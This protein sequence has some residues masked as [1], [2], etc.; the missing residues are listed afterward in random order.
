MGLVDRVYD[1]DGGAE[2]RFDLAIFENT[3][4]ALKAPTGK[5][6]AAAHHTVQMRKLEYFERVS[7]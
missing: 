7:P 2:N 4:D 3:P 5:K 1:K 6:T